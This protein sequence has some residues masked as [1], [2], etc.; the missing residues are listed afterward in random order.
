[1]L[2]QHHSL[3]RLLPLGSRIHQHAV[4]CRFAVI[5]ALLSCR[6]HR[7]CLHALGLTLPIPLALFRW[8][9][10][11][12]QRLQGLLLKLVLRLCLQC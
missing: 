8:Q 2:L 7:C 9:L 1:M 5:A 10:S 12:H 6:C 11:M 4:H 3:R